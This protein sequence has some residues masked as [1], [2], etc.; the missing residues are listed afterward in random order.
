MCSVIQTGPCQCSTGLASSIPGPLT[1][2]WRVLSAVAVAV[3]V[4]TWWLTGP[5]ILPRARR[6]GRRYARRVHAAGRVALVAVAVAALAWPVTTGVALVAVGLALAVT[7]TVRR[8]RA[9]R[10]V[11]VDPAT[12]PPLRVRASVRRPV[13]AVTD[14]LTS[15]ERFARTSS[16]TRTGVRP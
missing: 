3:A 2:A 7:A 6:R 5:A 13:A 8:D 1:V 15:A 9:R 11:R 14:H 12:R 4:F 10:A 16:K